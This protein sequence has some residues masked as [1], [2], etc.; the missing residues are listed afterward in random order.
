MLHRSTSFPHLDA[1]PRLAAIACLL[2]AL[3]LACDRDHDSGTGEF[4]A[5]LQGSANGT[6]YTLRGALFEFDTGDY[7]DAEALGPGAS[8]FSLEL[9]AGDHW[10]SLLDGWYVTEGTSEDPGPVVAADL[11]TQNP[12]DFVIADGLVT[13]V[14]Y[15]FEI[16]GE[17]VDMAPGNVQVGV[18]FEGDDGVC[19]V[20][21]DYTP[22]VDFG[23]IDP[24]AV[25]PVGG[26]WQS[27]TAPADMEARTLGI[28]WGIFATNEFS[29]LQLHE[30]VG[31]DGPLIAT[32]AVPPQNPGEI[33]GWVHVA[34]EG[35]YPALVAG[36]TYTLYATGGAVG[37]MAAPT[38]MPGATSSEGT[39]SHRGMQVLGYLCD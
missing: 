4:R 19:E 3:A 18:E 38:A 16:E 8:T 17:V 39:N 37:W 14:N 27:F 11:L 21:G 9:P 20:V 6:T 7:F 28:W 22:L 2:A 10:V 24:L 23:G 36:Q 25:G 26:G 1:R 33:S 12:L 31:T 15:R 32:A 30:G 35:Q 5:G 29:A 13:Q 34:I